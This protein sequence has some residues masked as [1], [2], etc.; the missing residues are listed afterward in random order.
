MLYYIKFQMIDIL[1]STVKNYFINY[2]LY[3][4]TNFA[5]LS[6][7]QNLRVFSWLSIQLL[8][9]NF[10]PKYLTFKKKIGSH[11][12]YKQK[13]IS[14]R[15]SYQIKKGSFIQYPGRTQVK[16]ASKKRWHKQGATQLLLC[17]TVHCGISLSSGM[18]AGIHRHIPCWSEE[19]SWG[20]P[21]TYSV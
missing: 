2:I 17:G 14:T 20:W 19:A 1:K 4:S 5:W 8:H 12:L 10:F 13:I 15:I 21:F 7:P 6:Y 18:T 11:I 16:G 9:R 3:R